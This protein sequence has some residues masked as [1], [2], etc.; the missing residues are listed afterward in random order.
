[1]LL[2]FMKLSTKVMVPVGVPTNCATTL[3]VN[4]SESPKFDGLAPELKA[5]AEELMRALTYPKFKLTVE[6]RQELLADYL[7]SCDRT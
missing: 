2:L 5:T 4:V 7:R 6:E 3:A 1:M